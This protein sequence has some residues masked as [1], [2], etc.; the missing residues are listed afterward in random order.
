MLLVVVFD[1]DMI[2]RGLMRSRS[3]NWIDV[4]RTSAV[5]GG[6]IGQAQF[7]SFAAFVSGWGGTAG[8]E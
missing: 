6:E 7:K 8:L 1:S 2:G 3:S 5:L 4:L